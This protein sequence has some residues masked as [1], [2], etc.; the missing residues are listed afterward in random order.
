MICKSCGTEMYI[1]GSY[2]RVTGDTSPEEETVVERVLRFG[3]RN[4]HC[5]G[6]EGEAEQAIRLY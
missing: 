2:I 5:T 4:P 6:H 1:N 3:C